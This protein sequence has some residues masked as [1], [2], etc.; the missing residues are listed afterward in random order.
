MGPECGVE[1][2]KER[3]RFGCKRKKPREDAEGKWILRGSGRAQPISGTCRKDGWLGS[4]ETV[5]R[6]WSQREIP[7]AAIATSRTTHFFH[8]L[9]LIAANH[10]DMLSTCSVSRCSDL[11]RIVREWWETD[12]HA[13]RKTGIRWSELSDG[14]TSAPGISAVPREALLLHTADKEASHYTQIN[15]ETGFLVYSWS[16][17]KGL[18]NLSRSSLCRGTVFKM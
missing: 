8:V 2:E 7:G 13:D 6:L 1:L 10:F 3:L 15:K 18:T 14:T 16:K 4:M 5:F 9:F 11:T 17:G 12:R